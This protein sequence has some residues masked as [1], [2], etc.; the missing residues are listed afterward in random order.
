MPS[1]LGD[2]SAHD[3]DSIETLKDRIC[4]DRID[5]CL[6]M[7]RLPVPDGVAGR[8]AWFAYGKKLAQ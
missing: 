6:T 8:I 5:H 7:S 4:R 3:A 1:L 2:G